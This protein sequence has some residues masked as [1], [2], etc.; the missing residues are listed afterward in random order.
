[1]KFKKFN[2]IDNFHRQKTIDYY[3]QMGY[4]K[5]DIEWVATN[6][7]HGANFSY[8]TDGSVVKEAKRSGFLKED[9]Y[10]Y[11]NSR[12]PYKD[13][14]LFIIDDLG[15]KSLA[16]Y[17][18]I[19]GGNYPHQSVRKIQ[20]A[21]VVQKG[22]YYYPDNDFIIFDVVIDG[23][24]LTWDEIKKFGFSYDFIVVPE[25]ARGTFDDV[26]KTPEVF[27]D[28]V[29][30]QYGLPPIENNLSEGLVIKPVIP[31]FT[32]NGDRVMVKKKNPK[33]AEK[34][35]KPAKAKNPIILDSE[36]KAILDEMSLYLNNNRLRNV[37]SHG[38]IGEITQK[39]FGKLLGFFAKDALVAFS[40][41]NPDVLD[42]LEKKSRK[43]IQK[44]F[45]KIAGD[46][47]R[48]NFVNIID[49]TF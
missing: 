45:N 1:M 21:S 34:S 22:V 13:D 48:P 17:G 43:K 35:N 11:G 27:A 12:L 39:S 5:S 18:E 46:I 31:I 32:P 6:K 36:E 24:F 15:A 19:F 41:D 2:S 37:L 42:S 29:Y 14:I 3:I 44:E 16:I 49:G 7:V 33:F 38:E 4:T 9:E 40:K 20:D 8:W 30:R 25:I 47:I 28:P 10:F 26:I 23:K